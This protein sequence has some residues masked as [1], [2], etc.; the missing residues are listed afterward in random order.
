VDI[1]TVGIYLVAVFNA[2]T[3]F[4]K[5]PLIGRSD[6]TFS[7]AAV[8]QCQFIHLRIYLFIHSFIHSSIQSLS[9]FTFRQQM[10]GTFV[11]ALFVVLRGY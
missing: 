7:D 11:F 8:G 1:F 4:S 10:S 3:L 6:D 5:T 2:W 9:P